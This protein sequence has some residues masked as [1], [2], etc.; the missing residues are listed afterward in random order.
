MTEADQQGIINRV[1]DRYIKCSRESYY[2]S[3][4]EERLTGIK[5]KESLN[6]QERLSEVRTC[7]MPATD[8]D[9]SPLSMCFIRR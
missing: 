8:G 3:V 4:D 1:L 9:N 7:G 5:H 6:Y 2:H